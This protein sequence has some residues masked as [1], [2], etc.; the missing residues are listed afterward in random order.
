M[1][2][3]NQ[4]S[5]MTAIVASGYLF[6]D[7]LAYHVDV[8]QGDTP[9]SLLERHAPGANVK[10]AAVIDIDIP[11]NT[12]PLPPEADEPVVVVGDSP[13]TSVFVCG[14][15]DLQ[16]PSD[17]MT[18]DVSSGSDVQEGKGGDVVEA[19][20]PPPG[21]PAATAPELTT[22]ERVEEPQSE[23]P[24]E[25]D[26]TVEMEIEDLVPPPEEPAAATATA[27]EDTN[28]PTAPLAET[29][30]RPFS[31]TRRAPKS[32]VNR[33]TRRIPHVPGSLKIELA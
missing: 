19:A 5:H 8:Y 9:A 17:P 22:P 23:K 28:D 32:K 16:S 7:E 1:A 10:N 26:G 11:G 18:K 30:E 31:R 2:T 4:A 20:V 21:T 27:P 24:V 12:E 3:P 33:H 6:A 13:R 25:G 29:A 15:R 14:G